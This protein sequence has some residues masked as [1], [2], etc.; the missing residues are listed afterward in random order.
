VLAA[1][2][3][4]V[5]G[6]V[7]RAAQI[8]LLDIDRKSGRYTLYAETFL[9]AAPDD[10]YSVLLDYDQF[11]R[12]SSVYKEHGYLEPADDGTPIVYTLMEGCMMFYCLSMRRV[13]RLETE[14]PD[15][16][17]PGVIR[18]YTLP[19]ESDFTFSTSEWTLT[20][21][22]GGTL[23]TYSLIM[24]PDFWVPPVIGPWYLKRT[25]KRGGLTAINRIERLAIEVETVAS[26][27]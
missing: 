6:P 13:E 23:M 10:I 5:A 15:A 27:K 20:P 18:T 9:S 25:L 11:D 24:E 22:P 26:L 12:I 19:E 1:L 2:A 21:Q 8:R 7:V 14:P 3:A 16:Q 17:H 4:G